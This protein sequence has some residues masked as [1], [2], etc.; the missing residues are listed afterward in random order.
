MDLGQAAY[1]SAMLVG[2][3]S[4]AQKLAFGSKR[5][6]QITGL[7]LAVAI[8][9]VFL[10]GASD[11][12]HDQIVLGKA[13]DEISVASKLTLA[14]LIVGPASAIWQTLGAVANIGQ[15]RLSDDAQ[16][17]QDRAMAAALDRQAEQVLGTLPAK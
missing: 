16:A 4:M 17:L 5:E 9:S 7:V 14:L 12:A 6:R 8:G 3:A 1:L 2:L 10:V 13:L 11:W 15:N